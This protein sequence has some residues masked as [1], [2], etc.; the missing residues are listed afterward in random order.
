MANARYSADPDDIGAQIDLIGVP[1]LMIGED[2]SSAPNAYSRVTGAPRLRRRGLLYRVRLH[3]SPFATA[4][5]Q[6]PEWWCYPLA[7]SRSHNWAPGRSS[8]SSVCRSSEVTPL[9]FLAV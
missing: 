8:L 9:V 6:R 2:A 7:R 4:E 5:I 3:D 1:W